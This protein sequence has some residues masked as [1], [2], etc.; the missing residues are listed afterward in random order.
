MSEFFQSHF[1]II[2]F[3]LGISSL[4]IISVLYARGRIDRYLWL[5]FL[6]GCGLGFTWEFLCNL[7]IAHGA[8]PVARFIT[9][10]PFHYMIIVVIHSFWDGALFTIG[11]WL[12]RKTCA[13][14][15]FTS[16]RVAELAV[17]IVWG[18]AQEIVV[19]MISATGAAWEWLPYAWNPTLF[20]FNG[21]HITL[22]P[23]VIWFAATIAFYCI[24]L[25][26]RSKTPG[27]AATTRPPGS[28]IT[29]KSD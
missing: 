9:P 24:A 28:A 21:Y 1:Y 27:G 5:L 12:V 13:P 20:V 23:Q 2:D 14:P 16:F 8:S 10:L 3:I 22:L 11:A 25:T 17:I 29:L 6:V 19:E 18:Q 7:N 4:V 26:L 15:H